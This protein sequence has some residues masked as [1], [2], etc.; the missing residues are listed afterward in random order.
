M[1]PHRLTRRAFVARAAAVGVAAASTVAIGENQPHPQDDADKRLTKQG[2]SLLISGATVI[3]GRADEPL[4]GRSIWIEGGRIKAVGRRDDLGNPRGARLIDARGK[5]IIPGLMNA[6]VH[7]FGVAGSVE[8]VAQHLRQFDD[9]IAESAQLALRNGLTTV[10]DTYG[11][12]RF[13][14]AVRDRINAGEV[15]GS[16]LFCAGN[17]IGLDGPFSLDMSIKALEVS[18]SAL[19]RRINS[20]WTENVGRHLMWQPP[21]RV[22]KEVRAYIARG[23]DFIKYAAN[24]HAPGSVGA[25]LAFSPEAQSAMV[26]EAHRAGIAAQAHTMS[27]E[28]LRI[29][30]EAGCD[31]IQHANITGPVAIPESTLRLLAERKTGTVIFPWTKRGFDWVMANDSETA[32]TMWAASDVNARNLIRSG[33]RLLMAND[34]MILGPEAESVGKTW[35]AMP[36]EDSLIDLRYGHFAWFRAMEEKG[37]PPMEMLRAATRNV[38]LAYGKD[39]DLG[40]LEPGKIADLLILD[41]NPL[42]AAANYRSIHSVI[43]EGRVVDREALPIKPI[44]TGKV[45][46]PAEEEASYI[47]FLQ[48]TIM[49][50]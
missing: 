22:A 35:S 34:G 20:I 28:G 37:C 27:V 23:V 26:A 4:E 10:F 19:R 15:Q 50:P 30:V 38:A 11:P 42:Q 45:D 46:P 3:D 29:A 1:K 31:L 44:L 7:L 43:K 8:L 36:G 14:M 16:R 2:A 33:A 25:F 32:R 13:L 48:T 39:K 47:P 18:S 12:R 6:N 17:I 9:I 49:P 21:D 5:Y 40:T 41:K 24:D